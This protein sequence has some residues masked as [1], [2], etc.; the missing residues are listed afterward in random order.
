MLSRLRKKQ[1]RIVWYPS[2]ASVTP[3]TTTLMVR[4]Y[5]GLTW[6][7]L[8]NSRPKD[9]DGFS[10]ELDRAMWQAVERVERW[11]GHDLFEEI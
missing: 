6:V 8:F 11:P 2:T 9:S 5:N 3:G 1:E 10:G 7:A 4:T